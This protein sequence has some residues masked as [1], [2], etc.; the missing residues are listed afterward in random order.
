MI[1]IVCDPGDDHAAAVA[2]RLLDAGREVEIVDAVGLSPDVA[3]DLEYGGHDRPARRVL[4][5][6]GRAIDLDSVTV[7]WWRRLPAPVASH[8]RALLAA[9]PASADALESVLASLDVVWINDPAADRASRRRPVLWDTAA[10]AGLAVPH[11]LVTRDRAEALTFAHEHAEHGV[12]VTSIERRTDDWTSGTRLP[13]ASIPAWFDGAATDSVLQSWVEGIDV[14]VIVVGTAMYTVE[15]IDRD[16]ET[17]VELAIA[18][19]CLRRADLPDH[20]YEALWVL[21]QNLGLITAS[22]DLRK[23]PEGHHVLI[24]LDPSPRWADIERRTAWPIT[25]AVADAITRRERVLV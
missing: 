9:T 6:H 25:S 14:R 21:M 7:G 8:D 17:P 18:A 16:D 2:A 10:L 20:V 4:H 22:I 24:D 1:L 23:T 12:S 5:V 11:T 19:G 13:A 3:L 15:L